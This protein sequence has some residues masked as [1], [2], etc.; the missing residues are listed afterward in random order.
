MQKRRIITSLV[1]LTFS[2]CSFTTASAYTQLPDLSK[3]DS[4]TYSFIHISDTQLYSYNYPSM[5]CDMTDWIASARDELNIRFVAH[6]GDII[7]SAY[8]DYQ[9]RNAK[10]ATK[11]IEAAEI[12]RLY[13]PGNHDLGQANNYTYFLKNYGPYTYKNNYTEFYCNKTGEATAQIVDVGNGH[14]WVFIGLGYVIKP[15]TLDWAANFIAAH[16]DYPTV[17]V[18]HSYLEADGSINA[19]GE[20]IARSLIAPYKNVRLVLCG[21]NYSSATHIT[22]YDDDGDGISD[23]KVYAM[24]ADY[25]TECYGR[26]CG[27]FRVL[28]VSEEQHQIKVQT[29]ITSTGEYSSTDQF[30]IKMDGSWFSN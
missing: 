18:T 3:E 9:W 15:S 4:S 6:S 22:E 14:C 16:P 21:H 29:Y 26:E 30:T 17:I 11:T 25:Q 13:V 12:P 2:L 20:R 7:D 5:F 19:N 1:A 24:L 10:T 23:R 27:K 8:Q 28:T